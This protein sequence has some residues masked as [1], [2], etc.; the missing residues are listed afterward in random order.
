MPPPI[1][2]MAASS[3]TFHGVKLAG[4]MKNRPTVDTNAS[5][6]NFSTVV[7]TCTDFMFFTPDR[8]INAGTHRPTSTS[9]IDT[10]LLW[11]LLRNTST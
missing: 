1:A 3:L 5:A 8:L 9:R 4:S 2:V 7:H 6:A 11:L 10:S